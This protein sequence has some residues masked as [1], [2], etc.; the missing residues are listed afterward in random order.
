[1]S[2]SAEPD[3][4]ERALIFDMDGVLIDS[5]P[6][7]RRAE[8]EVFGAVGLQLVEADCFK[9]QGLRIDEAVAYW[10]ARH[11]WTGESCE[12][13]ADRIVSRMVDLIQAEGE[14]MRGVRE[15]IEA[16]RQ[17]GW[18]LGLAS[19]SSSRLIETVLDRFSLAHAFES[20]RSAENE[21]NGK[22]A[23]DVYLATARE[24]GIAP[25][26]CVA[27]EDS[28]N[29]IISALAAGMRCIVVPDPELRDDPRFEK[30]TKSIDSLSALP[31]A[32][33]EMLRDFNQNESAP[34]S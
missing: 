15:S 8:I 19:S 7:W 2:A 11:P 24:M 30:A 23:P 12:I 26:R 33:T 14:P 16:A 10:Y 18:R 22:P 20:T 13:V 5:E 28:P 1:M 3:S 21:A 17:Q 6:L 27:V 34:A 31:D 32:L 9:T 25:D 4:A 29:G